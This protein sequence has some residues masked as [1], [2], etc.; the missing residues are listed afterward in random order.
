VPYE[1]FTWLVNVV[2]IT[3]SEVEQISGKGGRVLP[4]RVN[5]DP[6]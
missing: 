5:H 2:N 3:S 6:D 1:G 4:T